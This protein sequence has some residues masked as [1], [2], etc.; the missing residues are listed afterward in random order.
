MIEQSERFMT[1]DEAADLLH[2]SRW[3]ILRRVKAG[4]LDVVR[5]GR[6]PKAPIRIAP[7]DLADYL[8]RINA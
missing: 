1:V 8:R 6:G 7:G 2:V 3:S 4:D 5:V